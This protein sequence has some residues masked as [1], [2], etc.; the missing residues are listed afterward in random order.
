M[1]PHLNPALTAT[2]PPA[3]MEAYR[4]LDAA[5][6]HPDKPL[7]NISQAAPTAPPPLPLRHAMADLLVHETGVHLYG[8][9]LGLPAL[10]DE[11]S[12]QISTRYGGKIQA[13]QIA[14]T[15]GCNQAFTAAI[16]TL[17]RAG[18]S[19]ILPVPWYFNHKMWLDMNGIEAVPLATGPTLI[20]DPDR[21]ATLITERTRAI[22]LISPNNPAGV[23]YPAGILRGFYD[24]AQRHGLA[25][26]VD[27]TYRDFDSR[28]G[29]PHDLF[30]DPDWPDTLIHLYSFSKAYRLTGHRVGAMASSTARLQEVE[31]YIDSTTICANQLAQHAA[32]WGLRNLSD[33]LAGERAD[34][35]DRRAAMT[36]QLD[37]LEG[38]HLRGI[39]AY[40]AFVDH[41]F[42]ASS[43][44][45]AQ[46]LVRDQGVLLLPAT[47][48][49]PKNDPAGAR[50][51][52][53][54]FANIDRAGMDELFTRLRNL[55]L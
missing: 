33:W 53:I 39:G 37:R 4:W 5:P 21:A 32:L 20:P 36:A 9:D 26:I 27:E 2:D 10:R 31:K 23:E 48:F 8:P 19:V 14:I 54:A 55:V 51:C 24:L 40:F 22:V 1:A 15:A 44:D 46:R 18:D 16:A 42:D 17:A 25:L 13:G 43:T 52:R 28:D 45:V 3:I 49:T 41:P 6:S 12:R 47:M 7:I 30:Q 50:A 34:I 11:L 35:L 38:W 29:A